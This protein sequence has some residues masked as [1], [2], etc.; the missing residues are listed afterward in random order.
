MTRIF[1]RIVPGRE[2]WEAWPEGHPG[3]SQPGYSLPVALGSLVRAE[4]ARLG[5]ELKAFDGSTP[6]P[7]RPIP[8]G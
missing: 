7:N 4:A 6:A 5:L 2:S 3:R 8:D 1:Y